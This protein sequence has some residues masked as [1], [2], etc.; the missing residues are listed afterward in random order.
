M[1]KLWIT[2]TGIILLFG[3]FC[4]T[5]AGSA[6]RGQE[7]IL[8]DFED[9]KLGAWVADTPAGMTIAVEKIGEDNRA[10]RLN[11]VYNDRTAQTWWDNA[12]VKITQKID[13]SEYNGVVFDVI[14]DASA[15]EGY[16]AIKPAACIMTEGWKEFLNCGEMEL[17]CAPQGENTGEYI[18]YHYEALL[19]ENTGTIE[20]L[21]LWVTG[22]AVDY[23]KAVYVDN[24]GFAK[25]TFEE[26]Q[27]EPMHP[28][29]ETPVEKYGIL[30]VDGTHLCAQDG[31]PIQLTGMSFPMLMRN[32]QFVNRAIFQAFAY[33]WKC[34]VVRLAVDIGE[35]DY[36][37]TAEQKALIAQAIDLAVENGMYVLL[38][39]H[40]LTPGNPLDGAY[41]GAGAFFDE[42]SAKY[43]NCP[44][45]IYEICNE[46]NG[47]ITWANHIKPYAEDII[48]I[49]RKNSPKSVVVV[50]T[51][52]WS[53]DVQDPANDPIQK[54]NIM[55]TVHFYAGS[56]KQSLRDQVSYALSKNI[57]IFATEWGIT[58]H[59]GADGIFLE[60]TQLWLD[61]MK[62]NKISWTNWCFGNYSA[63]S[64]V[65]KTLIT[66]GMQNGLYV[67]E[68]TPVVPDAV[69]ENGVPYWSQERLSF[70]GNYMRG[71][72][73]AEHPNE[74]LFGEEKVQIK[75]C[76]VEETPEGLHITV[77]PENENG[78]YL[79]SYYVLG[80][81]HIWYSN[82]YSKERTAVFVPEKAGDYQLRVYLQSRTGGRTGW[83]KK[84]RVN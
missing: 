77:V 37:G 18:V 54:E 5:A 14:L 57:A 75:D 50:G 71:L 26:T 45:V 12:G 63:E 49:I 70:A 69:Y 10:L 82:V 64:A 30:H 39:W 68:C 4:F 60:E 58:T 31:T 83:N 24:V 29:N 36:T 6:L 79:Y 35:N 51:G 17:Q 56:H 16:G 81:G 67:K 65:L 61:F 15:I 52:T 72:L 44:N 13:L 43:A 28:L 84:V 73:R 55:Y 9:G 11:H 59:T 38:D 1:K 66:A 34:E 48:S 7:N 74:F 21:V 27:V 20:Q 2:L 25:L 53:Q 22:G 76:I 8:W 46:P 32:P 80:E 78:N 47:N 41:A 42:F 33:D 3:V 19:P 40:V 23:S 62:E